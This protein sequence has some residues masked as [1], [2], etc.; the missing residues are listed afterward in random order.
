MQNSRLSRRMPCF[1]I[2]VRRKDVWKAILRREMNLRLDLFLLM[3]CSVDKEPSTSR[4]RTT[5]RNWS[6]RLRNVISWWKKERKEAELRSGV[7]YY[8]VID[9]EENYLFI[10]SR[11]CSNQLA[12]LLKNFKNSASKKIVVVSRCEAQLVA[13]EKR[14]APRQSNWSLDVIS[15]QG[16]LRLYKLLLSPANTTSTHVSRYAGS[17]LSQAWICSVSKQFSA[18]SLR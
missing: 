2:F 5:N 15:S 4:L 8:S 13:G 9:G 14:K 11:D 7:L 3:T 12:T 16:L 17:T 1:N 18:L 10:G 6:R